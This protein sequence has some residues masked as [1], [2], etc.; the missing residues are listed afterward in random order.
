MNYFPTATALIS[1][2]ETDARFDL[3]VDALFAKAAVAKSRREA[4]RRAETA[5]DSARRP[6][7]RLSLAH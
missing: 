7:K 5:R 1:E 2:K 6:A 3:L 4:T